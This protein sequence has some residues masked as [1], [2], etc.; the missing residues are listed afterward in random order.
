LAG[1]AGSTRIPRQWDWVELIDPEPDDE[2]EQGTPVE[3]LPHEAYVAYARYIGENL[4]RIA[5]DG[6]VPVCFEEFIESE[7]CLEYISKVPAS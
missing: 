5:S 7:E 6:W 1:N 3:V 2:N 4:E